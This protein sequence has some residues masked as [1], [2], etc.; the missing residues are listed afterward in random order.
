MNITQ[1]LNE[2]TY[3]TKPREIA[4]SIFKKAFEKIKVGKKFY[5]DIS[6]YFPDSPKAV[7]FFYKKRIDM[8]DNANAEVISNKFSFDIIF[9]RNFE[10]D[11]HY[12]RNRE[13]AIAESYRDTIEHEVI[14]VLDF[15]RSNGKTRQS[16]MIKNYGSISEYRKA[17]NSNNS[18]ISKKAYYT[19][20]MEFNRLL[21]QMVQWIKANKA[22]FDKK[23][24]SKKELMR[25]IKLFEDDIGTAKLFNNN[26]EFYRALILRL[27][28]EGVLP[29]DFK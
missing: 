10:E 23:I 4:D 21:N 22:G 27:N 1:V 26:P 24:T 13:D 20:D 5:L 18:K 14:H 3:G 2:A 25:F 28:R 11:M 12:N 9:Y 15:V 8:N 16:K 17:W 29:K 19:H 6:E 7:N